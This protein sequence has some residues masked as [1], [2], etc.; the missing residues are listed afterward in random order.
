MRPKGTTKS[1]KIITSKEYKELFN[2][3]NR[4]D[5]FKTHSIKNAKKAFALLY[6]GGFRVS[7][8]IDFTNKDLF[9]IFKNK[10]FS[11]SNNTKTK[12]PRMVYFSDNAIK[13]LKLIF[14]ENLTESSNYLLLRSWGKPH[15]NFSAHTIQRQLNIILKIALGQNYTTHSFRAGIITE[16]AISGINTK[17]IQEFIN[18]SNIATTLRYVKPSEKDIKK[19]LVR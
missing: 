18:H 17:I 6:Y 8:I 11:L 1:R 9:E 10:E 4:T 13:E 3:L 15:N 14:R 5:E 12:K 7:E 16:M 2:Y 19:S